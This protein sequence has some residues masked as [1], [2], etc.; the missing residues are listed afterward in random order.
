MMQPSPFYP[1]LTHH[2]RNRETRLL[3]EALRVPWAL[4]R[5]ARAERNHGQTLL[6]LAERGGLCPQEVWANL[7]DQRLNG[8]MVRS[9]DMGDREVIA[10]IRSYVLTARLTGAPR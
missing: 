4:M 5:E 2:L 3:A 6:R 9:T 7:S 8:K 10:Q 1:V